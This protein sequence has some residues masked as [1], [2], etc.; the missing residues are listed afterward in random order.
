MKK[1]FSYEKPFKMGLNKEQERFR[2]SLPTKQKTRCKNSGL[3]MC[4][5][6]GE[7]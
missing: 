1:G 3:L 6:G 4:G 5:G 2:F 7:I